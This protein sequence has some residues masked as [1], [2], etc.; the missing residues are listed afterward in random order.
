VGVPHR[1]EE[2]TVACESQ[3]SALMSA[4]GACAPQW[5]QDGFAG[6]QQDLAALNTQ[7]QRFADCVAAQL[8]ELKQVQQPT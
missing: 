2:D 8:D 1:Q 3:W 7:A 4:W 5:T 6:S